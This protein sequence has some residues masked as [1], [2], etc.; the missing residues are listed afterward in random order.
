MKSCFTSKEYLLLLL[1]M[2]GGIGMFN[3]LYTVMQ[4]LLCPS[5]YSNSFSGICAALMI[6]GGV[7]GATAAGKR[8]SSRIKRRGTSE[9]A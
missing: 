3:C 6:I 4:Q 7:F 1:V 8:A 2:G 5:G 9:D